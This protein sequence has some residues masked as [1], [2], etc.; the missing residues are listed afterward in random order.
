M[1][2]VHLTVPAIEFD[3]RRLT[4]KWRRTTSEEAVSGLADYYEKTNGRP[5]VRRRKGCSLRSPPG[6]PTSHRPWTG[7]PAP[8]RTAS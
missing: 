5:G 4:D 7:R 6:R 8:A 2:R 1:A 3:A